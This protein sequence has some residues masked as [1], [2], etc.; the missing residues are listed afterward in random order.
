[1][2]VGDKIETSS[3]ASEYLLEDDIYQN[4]I[5]VLVGR[6]YVLIIYSSSFY[7]FVEF[8]QEI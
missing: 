5:K 8:M 4:K 6:L 2:L 7:L 3:L 1:M